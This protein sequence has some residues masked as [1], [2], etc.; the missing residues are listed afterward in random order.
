MRST[1]IESAIGSFRED[2]PTS[3]SAVDEALDALTRATTIR[4][5]SRSAD[6]VAMLAIL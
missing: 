1:E 2:E 4:K 6:K 3:C 5:R